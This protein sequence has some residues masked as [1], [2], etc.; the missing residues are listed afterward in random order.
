MKKLFE[1]GL[2]FYVDKL[3]QGECFSFN[4][5]GNGEW[6]C[7]FELFHRTRSGSQTFTPEL[8][9]AITNIVL[10]TPKPPNY[11]LALQNLEYLYKQDLLSKIDPWMAKNKKK[12]SWHLADVFHRASKNGELTQ[13]TNALSRMRV[14]VVGPPWLGAL[15]FATDLVLVAKKDCWEGIDKTMDQLS[16]LKDCVISFSAG[17]AAKVLIDRLHPLVGDTCWLLD[18][19]SLWD[20]YCGVRSR[21]YHRKMDAATISVNLGH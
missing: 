1:P 16:S 20:P 12:V 13:L 8:R 2:Q 6:D 3:E 11:Y 7:I 19:G 5:L 21:S 9:Q 14:V 18:M 4:R 10:D 15:P 17:P